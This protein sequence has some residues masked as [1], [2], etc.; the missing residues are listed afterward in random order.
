MDQK[1]NTAKPKI[2]V[3]NYETMMDIQNLHTYQNSPHL[4]S[5]PNRDEQTLPTDMR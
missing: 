1:M 3:K 2:R 5:L 4:Q